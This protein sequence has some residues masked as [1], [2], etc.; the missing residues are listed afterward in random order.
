MG[1][2]KK[3]DEKKAEEGKK[4]KKKSKAKKGDKDEATT[5]ESEQKVE[6]KLQNES[7]SK[8]DDNNKEAVNEENTE[9]Q[10]SE[11]NKKGKEGNAAAKPFKRV[12]DTEILSTLDPELRDNSYYALKQRGESW[13]DRANQV[14]SSVK[15]KGFRHEK[16][17]KKRGS[18]RGGSIDANK[19]NSIRFD[20]A[21]V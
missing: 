16:T 4:K 19:V 1:N 10:K 5:T 2:T 15:G 13:G 7:S 14:L 8:N 17:K 6:A 18:Y 12:N 20:W 3:E 11:E 21:W 9:T